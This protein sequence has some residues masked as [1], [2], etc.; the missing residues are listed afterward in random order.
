M[1]RVA[2]A[3]C[4]AS[5]A[6]GAG[7]GDDAG[8]LQK[9]RGE[10]GV[11]EQHVQQTDAQRAALERQLQQ[12]ETRLAELH[13]RHTR[14]AQRVAAA[15]AELGTLEKAR[16]ALKE[17]ATQQSRRLAADA[18]VAYRL[19]R[20]EPL[21]V[22]LNMEDPQ[23]ARRMMAYYGRFITARAGQLTGYQ[24]TLQELDTTTAA[25]AARQSLLEADRT[26]LGDA[27]RQQQGQ[28]AAR[29]EAM[30]AL[31]R[32]LTD[33]RARLRQ[34]KTEER[35]LRDVLDQLARSTSP[36]G[37][38]P[39]TKQA[40]KLP[41]PVNGKPLNRFGASRASALPWTGWMI[42]VQEGS[43]VHVI[44]AG[45]V[46]FADYLR[47]HGQLIIVDHGGG[48][49]SLYSHNQAL[50]K[51]TGARVQGG[52]VIARTGASGGLERGALYFEIRQGGKT[53]DPAVW[54]RKQS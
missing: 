20:S 3:W 2:L 17:T 13:E 42:A 15:E 19:G 54:L 18:A 46:V 48:Y 52:E 29:R 34:L 45:T 28:Q 24:T 14:L 6:A 37:D 40:G 51:A 32:D 5:L 12:A 53:L 50:L 38:G 43:A 31:A 4:L 49:L 41:W 27:L 7:A 35:R 9:L 11:R 47:G 25:I 39:F 22:L 21:K 1:K 8:T 44:H 26:A 10:I 23:Q 16:A 30:A 33:G 36:E